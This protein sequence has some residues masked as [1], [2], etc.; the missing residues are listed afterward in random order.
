DY[1]K[2]IKDALTTAD[3]WTPE[4]GKEEKKEPSK[5]EKEQKALEALLKNVEIKLPKLIVDEEV[6]ARLAQLLQ[7]LEKLGLT[8]ESYLAS[9]SK[10]AEQLREEYRLQAEQA[11]KLDFILS[12]IGEKENVEVT[13]KEVEDFAQVAEISPEQRA[14][15]RSMLRKR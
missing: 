6:N 2:H 1:K 4:K 5:E 14:G 12:T 9:I 7:R 8:L 13:D 3:I 11:L 10:S 15:I